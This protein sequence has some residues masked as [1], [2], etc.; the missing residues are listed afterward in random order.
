[1]YADAQFCHVIDQL[2]QLKAALH[3]IFQILQCPEAYS[4]FFEGHR[5]LAVWSLC[6]HWLSSLCPVEALLGAQFRIYRSPPSKSAIRETLSPS[7]QTAGLSNRG[8]IT[9]PHQHAS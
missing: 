6:G 9:L 2:L 7:Q 8:R 1:G 5:I 4:Y 3:S